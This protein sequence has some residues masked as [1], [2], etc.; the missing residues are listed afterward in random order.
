MANQVAGSQTKLAAD[1]AQLQTDIESLNSKLG[2][3]IYNIAYT[4]AASVRFNVPGNGRYL[5]ISTTAAASTQ[6]Y[7]GL[8]SSTIG[9][10]VDTANLFKG[11]GVTVATDTNVI[12]LTFPGTGNRYY[13]CCSLNDADLM[14]LL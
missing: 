10:V 11:D 2:R 7:V 6:G 8:V 14:S 3:Q 4:N 5:F 1:V 9:G 12:T 13:F